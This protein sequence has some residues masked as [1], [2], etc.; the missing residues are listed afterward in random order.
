MKSS[1]I[2]TLG[3]E[4]QIVPIA[5]ALLARDEGVKVDSVWVVHTDAQ[6]EPSLT[7]LRELSQF[8]AEQ[9]PHIAYHTEAIGVDGVPLPDIDDEIGAKAT[10]H[11]LYQLVRGCILRG[12]QV[13]L[14]AVGGRKTMAIY[15]MVVA[16]LL[17]GVDD[18]LWN[19]VSSG[20]LLRERRMVLQDGDTAKLVPVPVIRLS[21][22]PVVMLGLEGLIYP[23]QMMAVAEKRRSAEIDL[24][25]EQVLTRRER[26][27]LRV[28]VVDSTGTYEDS[29]ERLGIALSTLKRHAE[30]IYRKAK[31]QFGLD[32]INRAM[33]VQI[34]ASYHRWT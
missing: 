2:A 14:C 8:M 13:H 16:Q 1:L 28:L 12:E 3:S 7:A 23:E 6:V 10:F 34:L 4:R 19:I 22:I 9:L 31:A 29:A 24:F 15:A 17:F 26:E 11:T 20:A 30:S 25:V 27:V 32:R 5:L 33:L 18:R 21:N